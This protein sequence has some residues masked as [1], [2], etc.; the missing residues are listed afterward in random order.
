MTSAPN[1]RVYHEAKV[2]EIWCWN[3]YVKEYW[4]VEEVHPKGRNFCR[5]MFTSASRDG[6][7]T[8]GETQ[9]YTFWRDLTT[10]DTEWTL[11]TEVT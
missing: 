5:L 1:P 4:R 11:F 6:V 2:G 9:T 3:S 7:L 8:L 10:I